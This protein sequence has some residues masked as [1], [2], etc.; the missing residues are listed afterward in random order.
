MVGAAADKP[1]PA[2]V[3]EPAAGSETRADDHVRAFVEGREQPRYVGRI[4]GKIGIQ[5][6]DAAVAETEA[7]I[8]PMS[9]EPMPSL[10][11]RTITAKRGSAAAARDTRMPVVPSVDR[12]STTNVA[13]DRQRQ[14]RVDHPADC[15]AL[16]V[17]R[18]KISTG[19]L[20]RVGRSSARGCSGG[21]LQGGAFTSVLFMAGRL[22]TRLK[23]RVK[24]R[25]FRLK[26]PAI[27]RQLF[28]AAVAAVIVIWADYDAKA[29]A[30]R[31]CRGPTLVERLL[32]GH[33]QVFSN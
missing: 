18:Q 6:H 2:D 32:V 1:A 20:D 22:S 25:G 23:P 12:S 26:R 10:P 16:V 9:T 17:G 5:R 29:D 27:E 4:V 31:S 28:R 3:V 15:V 33:L 7:S 19:S 14:Q 24:A 13:G 8:R 21:R 30:C 11:G